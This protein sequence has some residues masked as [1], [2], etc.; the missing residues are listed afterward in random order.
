[1]N[2]EIS[3]FAM[4]IPSLAVWKTECTKLMENMIIRLHA[5]Q[6]FYYLVPS[7]ITRYLL[8]VFLCVFLVRGLMEESEKNHTGILA[9][10]L[11]FSPWSAVYV[12]CPLWG[13]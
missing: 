12:D 2:A 13:A 8:F 3:A 1:M 7:G 5:S 4:V 11:C 9:K 10:R 6:I